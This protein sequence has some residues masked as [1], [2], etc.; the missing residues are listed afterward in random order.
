MKRN[1]VVAMLGLG[2][3]A[4]LAGCSNINEYPNQEQSIQVENTDNSKETNNTEGL[5]KNTEEL[6]MTHLEKTAIMADK[7]S[8]DGANLLYS[9][10]S[11]D[12]ALG[13]V[14]E[15][16][17]GNSREQLNNYL[18]TDNYSE[19]TKNYLEF[20]T[21]I[22]DDTNTLEIANSIWLN[23]TCELNEAYA[24]IV[25]DSFEAT[26]ENLDFVNDSFGAA[27]TINSWIN[28]KTHGLINEAIAPSN[29]S[30]DTKSIL[31]NSL[32]FNSIWREEWDTDENRKLEFSNE[33]GST[34]ELVALYGNVDCYFENDKATAFGKLYDNGMMFIGI[35]PKEI[36]DF[37]ITELNLDTLIESIDYSP[38]VYAEM[39]KLEYEYEASNITEALKELGVTDIFGSD[40]QITKLLKSSEETDSLYVNNILQKC[41]IIL[42]EKKTEAAATTVVIMANGIAMPSEK[43]YK[44]VILNRPYAYMIY[45]TVNNETIF[46]GKYVNAQ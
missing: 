8:R 9:P 31:V 17:E 42:D 43:E 14:A 37:T 3:V 45:D 28:D 13:L 25:K 41:K 10:M 36:G 30:A 11:L 5:D 2:L 15:G 16:S 21:S 4:S 39:M 27:N 6:K 19:K 22:N 29:I 24:T 20:I 23:K 38:E 7:L 44:E 40:A 35:L 32:Y 33:D 26:A 34:S 18:L 12:M 1:K 46:I